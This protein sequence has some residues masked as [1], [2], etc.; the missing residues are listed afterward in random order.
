MPFLCVYFAKHYEIIWQHPGMAVKTGVIVKEF[1]GLWL[2]M[3][4]KYITWNI[5]GNNAH[6]KERFFMIWEH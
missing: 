6:K 1:A 4:Y 5:D 2:N 3:D